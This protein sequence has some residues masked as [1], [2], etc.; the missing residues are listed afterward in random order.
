MN[1]DKTDEQPKLA[2][3]S[4]AGIVGLLVRLQALSAPRHRAPSIDE[5]AAL[6][7]AIARRLLAGERG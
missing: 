3:S 1:R 2:A 6:A 7:V 5:L 4:G